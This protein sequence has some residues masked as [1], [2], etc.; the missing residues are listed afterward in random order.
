MSTVIDIGTENVEDIN[1]NVNILGIKERKINCKIVSCF[2][3]G[4]CVIIGIII[5]TLISLKY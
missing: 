4:L 1:S 2:V 5:L 3:V